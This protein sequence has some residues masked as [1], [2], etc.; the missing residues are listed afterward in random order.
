[1]VQPSSP[2]DT[3]FIYGTDVSLSKEKQKEIVDYF[4]IKISDAKGK[5]SNKEAEWRE[6]Y[7]LLNNVRP[8]KTEPW[9]GSSNIPLPMASEINDTVFENIM[10]R[11][12]NANG[13]YN[14]NGLDEWSMKYEEDVEDFINGYLLQDTDEFKNID[15]LVYR[16]V[17]DDTCTFLQTMEL[18]D[19]PKL[20]WVKKSG[21]IGAVSG[22]V[23]YIAD[24]VGIDTSFGYELVKEHDSYVKC[25]TVVYDP[26]DVIVP[27][28]AI[29]SVDANEFIAFIDWK[30]KKDLKEKN[31]YTKGYYKNLDEMDKVSETDSR[32][33]GK[34]QINEIA[35]TYGDNSDALPI[36]CLYGR[37]D[38]DDTG[39][40]KNIYLVFE[41]QS[42]TFLRCSHLQTFHGGRPVIAGSMIP[43]PGKW[44][45]V[46]LTTITKPLQYEAEAINNQTLDNWN[47][48]VNKVLKRVKGTKI[49]TSN[50]YV[51][52]GMI[53]DVDSETDLTM[54]NLG[55]VDY[56]SLPLLNKII[57][58][59]NTRA[60]INPNFGGSSD[61]S[62]PRA[63]GKKVG[64]MIAQS[65][66]RVKMFLYRFNDMMEKRAKM[67]ISG[68][69]QHG[70][71]ELSYK[72]WDVKAND[73]VIKKL[74]REVLQNGK[75][76]YVL[77][78][79]SSTG[80]KENEKQEELFLFDML[81]KNPL[82]SQP[83]QVLAQYAPAQLR[84]IIENTRNLF[85]KYDKT[86]IERLIPGHEELLQSLEQ[87]ITSKIEGQL[88]QVT[89]DLM[90]QSKLSPVEQQ[91]AAQL[92]G[93][94]GGE[95]G[96]VAGQMPNQ[97]NPQGT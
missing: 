30:T 3:R 87:V 11:Y 13:I 27:V 82:F 37:Y 70:D 74:D 38:L 31:F 73:Y 14:V 47:L 95:A 33:A 23:D 94:Q 1:M 46:C 40:R 26:Y 72:V 24:K 45:G 89:A 39:E 12:N 61:S 21:V 20:K 6:N 22:A 41:Y 4:R 68:F 5:R 63:S 85:R 55:T 64:M 49:K 91:M 35:N 59:Q 86:Q 78:G 57:G 16:F 81:L 32:D 97:G 9:A 60:G 43:V 51:K 92:Q 25:K 53:V 67:I 18:C 34:E 69:A 56:N 75:F 96:N 66:L 83:P 17:H 54:L 29:D 79:L 93:G 15:K 88:K 62:D 90:N 7:D 10:D 84:T 36:I 65:S 52:P 48:C 58:F 42:G 44:D 50:G 2:S 19:N 76:Q 71:K 28:G 77:N 8:T 80:S